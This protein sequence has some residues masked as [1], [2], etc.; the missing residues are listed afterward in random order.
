ME[1][2]RERLLHVERRLDALADELHQISQQTTRIDASMTALHD[3]VRALVREVGGFHEGN[4]AHVS[5]RTRMHKIEGDQAAANAA[6]AA[7]DAAQ[8]MRRNEFT[9]KSKLVLLAFA[10]MGAAGTVVS[11]Y[12]AITGG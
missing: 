6:K 12:V 4:G 1:Q 9:W 10:A 5:L 3:N 7:L 2:I 11:T 8:A